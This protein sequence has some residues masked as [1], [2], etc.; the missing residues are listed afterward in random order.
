MVKFVHK[1]T[2]TFPSLNALMMAD[3]TCQSNYKDDY[4]SK[5]TV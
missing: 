5:D 3:I 2:N 1:Y 4:A